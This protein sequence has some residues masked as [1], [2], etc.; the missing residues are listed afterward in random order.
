M[1]PVRLQIP[2]DSRVKTGQQV[3]IVKEAN[4]RVI[5]TMFKSSLHSLSSCS[6]RYTFS[7]RK[8]E[9][10]FGFQVVQESIHQN[11]NSHGL[12]H[13]SKRQARCREATKNTSTTLMR[14]RN[15]TD[16]HMKTNVTLNVM[17]VGIPKV[18]NPKADENVL[19]ST[20][21]VDHQAGRPDI[22]LLIKAENGRRR[23]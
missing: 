11:P 18:V 17:A 3:L 1:R 10:K 20:E 22:S 15:I 9:P 5:L 19:L 4:K 7:Y 14:K 6:D 8:D 21:V 2:V 23:L 12:K 16:R 13:F